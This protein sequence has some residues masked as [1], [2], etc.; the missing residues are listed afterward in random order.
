MKKSPRYLLPGIGRRASVIAKSFCLLCIAVLLTQ[1][2]KALAP[3]QAIYLDGVNQYC[4][5]LQPITTDS[6]EAYFNTVDAVTLPAPQVHTFSPSVGSYGTIVHITGANFTPG[7]TVSFGGTPALAVVFKSETSLTA[8]VGLGTSGMIK[9]TGSGGTDYSNTDFTYLADIY[10]VDSEKTANTTA[11]AVSTVQAADWANACGDLQTALAA[12]AITGG[13]VWVKKGTYHPT[14][15]PAGITGTTS[16]RDFAFKL[17]S[18][19]FIY[20]GFA[21][22]ETSLTQR[23]ATNNATILTGDLNGDDGVSFANTSENAYHVLIGANVQNCTLDGFTIQGGNANATGTDIQLDGY[24]INRFNGGG[25]LYITFDSSP[26]IVNCHFIGNTA[27]SGAAI[28]ISQLATPYIAN[29]SFRGNLAT[30]IGGAIA[31]DFES[32]PY[33]ISSIFS[34]NSAAYGS[35]IGNTG[36]SSPV[37]INVTMSANLG[38][39]GAIYNYGLSNPAILNSVLYG[40]TTGIENDNSTPVIGYSLVQGLSGTNNGNLPGTTNPQFASPLPPGVSTGGVYTVQQCNP[41]I[42][43]GNYDYYTNDDYD[44]SQFNLDLLGYDRFTDSKVDIGAYEFQGE[45]TVAPSEAGIFYVAQDAPGAGTSWDCPTTLQKAIA[46]ADYGNQIW[47]AGGTYKPSAFPAGCSNCSSTRDYAFT[48]K[49]GVTIY[50]GFAGNETDISQRVASTNATILDGDIGTPTTNADN[51]YHVVVS[52]HNSTGRL[53]GVTIQNGNANGDNSIDA[54]GRSF[55]RS[56]GGGLLLYSLSTLLTNCIITGNSATLGGGIYHNMGGAQ[57]A[58][59]GCSIVN[60][61]STGGPGG[62]IY[63]L[64]GDFVFANCL[65]FDNSSISYGG[66]IFI[67]GRLTLSNCTMLNNSAAGNNPNDGGAIHSNGSTNNIQNSIIWGYAGPK[68]TQ[69]RLSAGGQLNNSIV[70][71]GFASA[72]SSDPLFVNASDIDGADNIL[73]T[74]DD[75]LQLQICSP[76]INA[77]SNGSVPEGLTTNI[78]GSNRI[79]GSAVDIG[80]YE[81]TGVSNGG[82]PGAAELLA[83]NGDTGSNVITDSEAT[84]LMVDASPCETVA[85]ILPGGSAPVT[86]NIAAQVWVDATV[87]EYNSIPYVQ[88]HYDI[89][90]ATNPNAATAAVTLYFTQS[91]FDAFN[92]SD[93][94]GTLNGLP[95][96]PTDSRGIGNLRINQYHGSSTG[97]TGLPAS[98]TGS[99]AEI[100]PDNDKIIWNEALQRWEVT[101]N[102]QGFSGFFIITQQTAL[103]LRLISFIGTQESST[104]HLKWQ[105]ADE[106]NTQSFELESSKDGRKF[107]KVTTIDA[108]STGDN[109]YDYTDHTNYKGITYY[110]LKMIDIGGS[111]TYS[112]IVALSREGKGSINLFPNPVADWLNLSLDSNLINSEANLYD[113]H[114]R[115]LRTIKIASTEELVNT[116]TL[117]TGVYIIKFK[118][119]SVG[120]FVKD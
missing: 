82:N 62:G 43:R 112:R 116:K 24:I 40:N 117:P 118:D 90:P 35:A 17:Q 3:G 31:I 81:Y 37:L 110:R 36:Q 45:A 120:T 95:A 92:G 107:Q 28:Y 8:T 69:I 21:G 59:T 30:L 83:G 51:C 96:N 54:S 87:Q 48:L 70:Q 7:S 18:N 74:A 89:E 65:F 75:G 106:V 52:S 108:V 19:M 38:S 114:G 105:T 56:S 79:Q 94:I 10:L 34:G 57:V 27:S 63:S 93:G 12:A 76:A 68:V 53:D 99:K 47:V 26:N 64:S 103:P 72:L 100:N 6:Y 91:E 13:Q 109:S 119:G 44:I 16:S 5:M 50:G 4:T 86:G 11:V 80:A 15:Y 29:C 84:M 67:S 9:V 102:V 20:G 78:T 61:S 77:G 101:F 73:G 1:A 14:A 71:G 49:A 98:Y 41:F 33:I 22:S 46:A 23:D 42:N 85:T 55:E 32:R 39:H 25:G 104:N 58:L 2:S 88:R 60:N 66:G 115:P 97:N 111:F 113:V